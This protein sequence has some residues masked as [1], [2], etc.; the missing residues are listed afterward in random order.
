MP[1]CEF[2]VHDTVLNDALNM[3]EMNMPDMPLT[4]PTI[5]C[6]KRDTNLSFAPT[7][8]WNITI[9]KRKRFGVNEID[10]LC[11]DRITLVIECVHDDADWIDQKWKNDHAHRIV[12]KCSSCNRQ[13]WHNDQTRYTI[14]IETHESETQNEMATA[15]IPNCVSWRQTKTETERGNVVWNRPESDQLTRAQ[16]IVCHR[17][18]VSTPQSHHQPIEFQRKQ[19]STETQPLQ[20]SGWRPT[21]RRLWCHPIDEKF[22]QISVFQSTRSMLSSPTSYRIRSNNKRLCW[23][24]AHCSRW[25]LNRIDAIY[26]SS[27]WLYLTF[28]YL[29]RTSATVYTDERAVRNKW[30]RWRLWPAHCVWFYRISFPNT[31]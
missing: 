7:I 22:I 17:W 2:N 20:W 31:V 1:A 18:L 3:L 25:L 27:R 19:Q 28:T 8:W 11:F 30:W 26:S 5:S 24:C 15:H 10:Y 4:P 14:L 23:P 12:V 16:I 21:I 13:R 6:M 29:P 9:W